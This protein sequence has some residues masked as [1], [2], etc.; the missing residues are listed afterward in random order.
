MIFLFNKLKAMSVLL[1]FVSVAVANA[2]V[3]IEV[4]PDS[5]LQP[6]LVNDEQGGLH[7]LYFKK[8]LKA[9]SAR[10]GHLYYREFSHEEKRFGDPVRVSSEAYN[11]QT[12]SI[13]RASMAV[14]GDGRVHVVWYLPRDNQYYYARSDKGR[15]MFEAQRSMV[16]TF[17]EGI[18]AGADI[19]AMGPNVALVWGA[20]DLSN[21]KERTVYMRI[22]TDNGKTFG[23]ESPVGDPDLG[24]CA[25]CSLAAEF[26]GGDHLAIAYR[27][28]IGGTGRHMQILNLSSNQNK[29]SNADVLRA[30]Y[31]PM[32]KMR[33]WTMS[34]CPL[35]TNDIVRSQEGKSWM[36]FETEAR[37]I[38]KLLGADI[39]VSAGEPAKA[40]RQKNPAIAVNSRGEKL[41]A[42][43][44]AISHSKG[45]ELQV[46]LV[47]SNNKQIGVSGL[48]KIIIP[49]YSFPAAGSLITGEFIVL[50]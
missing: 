48:E 8:R 28:A 12:F 35:S 20:G 4:T 6:R 13:A 1:L 37:T 2:Q 9:R 40:T 43:G 17:S 26:T 19:A 10:E 7:L 34:A 24:A 31:E 22:S 47:D 39:A 11:L 15:Q 50:F 21:E 45:G 27:S 25:C 14:D 36:A 38:Y 5:G 3:R 18:D 49:D 16:A 32:Q 44:E 29:F 42:W 23:P 30:E 41:V 33:E 46:R